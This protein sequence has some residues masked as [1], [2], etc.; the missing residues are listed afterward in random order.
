MENKIND[1]L[2]V[3]LGEIMLRL[4]S[5]NNLRLLQN[6]EFEATFGGGESNVVGS[7]AYLGMNSRYVTALPHND[8]GDNI[9][10]YLQQYNVDT[11]AIIRKN[12]RLGIYFL[13]AGSG[14]RPSK[15]IYDRENSVISKVS[16]GDFD[17]D[18][19]FAKATWFHITGITPAISEKAAE[20]AIYAVK[21][22]KRR[23]LTV[24]CDLNY[25]KKLWKY[26]KSP[27]EIMSVLMEYVDVVI[28]N[29]E[30]IQKTLNFTLDV[31]IGKDTLE[32]QKYE[33]MVSKVVETYSHLSHVAITLRESISANHN[34][35]S[36]MLY[37]NHTKQ[38]HYSR[39]Y[40]LTDIVDRVGGGDSFAAGLIFG[41]LTK[42]S[43]H[44]AIN[45]AVAASALKHTI[46]GDLNLS[47]V[48]EVENLLQGGG[49]GRVQR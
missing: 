23:G 3:S 32:T 42:N 29:E 20:L 2:V 10:R 30:D 26:G 25:R 36:A 46:F 9:I 38:F 15:V 47:T 1:N 11:S 22:A 4:K 40:Q 5:P 19:V 12:G 21:E 8:L 34:N 28:A 17:W 24:S 44:D 31:E 7:L 6:P 33:R 49:H 16:Y 18:K 14:P 39:K 13:E 45:F 35:W 43:A 37:D 27:H 41:L 48:E